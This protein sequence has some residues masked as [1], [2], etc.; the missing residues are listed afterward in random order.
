[1]P[2]EEVEMGLWGPIE[3][4]AGTWEGEGG[5]DTAFSHE[6]EEVLGTPFRERVTFNPFGPVV[7]GRQS[8]YGLDYRSSMWRGD[9]ELPFHTEVGYWLWDADAGEVMRA[10]V[11][12]RG[13]TVMAA[14]L[15]TAEATTFRM[16]AEAG[17]P[18]RSIGESIYLAA[19]AS[20]RSYEV[21]ISIPD[22]DTWSYEERTMLQMREIEELFAHTDHNTLHRIG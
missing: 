3:R 21:T 22:D 15:T 14:G 18:Q 11:V 1:V 7:N 12:P 9:E 13:I 19:N 5:L 6:K 10:F 8:V 16:S 2:V 17:H 4:L 20:T